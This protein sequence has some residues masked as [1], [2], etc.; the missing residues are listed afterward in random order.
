MSGPGTQE[1]RDGPP[2]GN[3][4]VQI[5]LEDDDEPQDGDLKSQLAAARSV[6][7]K[8]GAQWWERFLVATRIR[9]GTEEACYKCAYEDCGKTFS[10]RN[11]SRSAHDH[12]GMGVKACKASSN[13]AC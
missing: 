13:A 1:S 9:G 12:Y 7:A 2:A 3:A 8:G 6:K 11:P 10:I 5:V 4:N